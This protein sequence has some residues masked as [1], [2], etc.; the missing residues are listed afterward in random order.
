MRDVVEAGA[1][2]VATVPVVSL[3]TGR[4][5][6]TITRIAAAAS[7]SAIAARFLRANIDVTDATG[8]S[9]FGTGRSRSLSTNVRHASHASTCAPTAASTSPHANASRSRL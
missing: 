7:G 1:D 8:S 2:A 4:S 3:G 9:I 6:K 5:R